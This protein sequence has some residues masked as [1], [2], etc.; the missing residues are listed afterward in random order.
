MSPSR[1]RRSSSRRS[2]RRRGPASG[3]SRW[4]SPET[5]CCARQ[6]RPRR[7]SRCGSS[8]PADGNGRGPGTDRTGSWPTRLTVPAP[9]GPTCGGAGSPARF[10]KLLIR[11]GIA[12]TAAGPETGH[13]RSTRRSTSNGTPWSAGSTGSVQPRRRHP[14]RK[15]RGPLRGNRAHR[16]DQRLATPLKQALAEPADDANIEGLTTRT[17]PSGNPAGPSDQSST[18]WGGYVLDWPV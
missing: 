10:P 4:K 8:R 5:Q 7:A 17:A 1:S 15:T 6:G 18:R 2:S 12:A 11:S 3:R 16:R 14:V 9:T 13:L